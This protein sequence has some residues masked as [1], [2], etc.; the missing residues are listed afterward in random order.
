MNSKYIIH[1]LKSSFINI[2]IIQRDLDHAILSTFYLRHGGTETDLCVLSPVLCLLLSRETRSKPLSSFPLCSILKSSVHLLIVMMSYVLF[3]IRMFYQLWF[4]CDIL[5][6]CKWDYHPYFM[7]NYVCSRPCSTSM[8]HIHLVI[9]N[10]FYQSGDTVI[11]TSKQQ[12][13]QI[14]Y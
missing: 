8:L 1:Q 9:Y 14:P 2:T 11:S 5:T 4:F 7:E 6:Q 3:R 13:C 12:L 10:I